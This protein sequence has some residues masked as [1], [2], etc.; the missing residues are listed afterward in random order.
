MDFRKLSKVPGRLGM[1]WQISQMHWWSVCWFEIGAEQ[2]VPTYKNL[3]DWS[4]ANA[5]AA[6]RK[7]CV[8]GHI[9]LWTF[10]LSLVWGTHTLSMFR[11]FRYTLYNWFCIY[12][13]IYPCFVRLFRMAEMELRTHQLY[14]KH[15]TIDVVVF[16]PAVVI[17]H[18]IEFIKV[19]DCN[20]DQSEGESRG[21]R[22]VGRKIISN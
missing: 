3:K 8:R 7:L 21:G 13:H 16:I 4:R 22:H 15:W 20:D 2:T 18:R 19:C 1:V 17:G 5:G 14:T 9:L 12:R 6:P 10:F 11:Y